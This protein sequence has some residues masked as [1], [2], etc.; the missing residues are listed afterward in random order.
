MGDLARAG[1]ATIVALVVLV[2]AACGGGVGEPADTSFVALDGSPRPPDAAGV[3]TAIAADNST[4]TID[5][6]HVYELHES[7][8]SFSSVDGSTQPVRSRVGQYVHVGL[9]GETA[10]W[11]AGIGAVTRIDGRPQTVNYIGTIKAVDGRQIT[12]VDG[13]VFELADDVEVPDSVPIGALLRVGVSADEVVELTVADDVSP[14]LE[15][16]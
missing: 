14:R 11:L 10:L 6:E 5:G 1:R 8:Q 3:L 13:A 7:L 9:D 12:M 16:G 4:I 15:E 2:A